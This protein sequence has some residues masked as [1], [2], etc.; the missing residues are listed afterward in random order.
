MSASC[1]PGFLSG[2]TAALKDSPDLADAQVIDGPPTKYLKRDVIAVGL[3][4]EDLAVETGK[5]DAG[6]GNRHEQADVNCLARSWSGNDDLPARRDHAF[7]LVD[8]VAAVLAADPTVG[9]T[10]VR[11]RVA[12]LVYSAL[13]SGEGT[14]ALI[15]FRVRF[16]AFGT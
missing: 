6:L 16:D 15:E 8:A 9:G 5:T 14:G 3:T 4:T 11:A 13:R 1:L 12:G 7:A 2:L 10:V